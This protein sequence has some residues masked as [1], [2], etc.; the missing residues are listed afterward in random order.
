MLKRRN[1]TTK[2]KRLAML[3]K[4]I[5][6]RDEIERWLEV[7]FFPEYKGVKGFL[8]T[9]D[10]MFVGSNPSTG[11]FPSKYDVRPK[12]V[13]VWF[14]EQLRK[15]GFENA[16]I[17]D[18]MKIRASG[19]EV[20]EL[21]GNQSLFN[22]QLKFLMKEVEIVR[23]KMVVAMG[24]KCYNILKERVDIKIVKI[25]HYSSTRFPKNKA[26]LASQMA[27]IAEMKKERRTHDRNKAT[28]DSRV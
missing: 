8:G 5:I 24:N 26:K 17:T 23:P 14:Y 10:V 7:W 28:A 13:V 20:D 3:R 2:R 16:H 9:Q 25:L 19:K 6:N 22:E 21:F 18:L 12:M 1:R 4:E 15:H 11:R 27:K